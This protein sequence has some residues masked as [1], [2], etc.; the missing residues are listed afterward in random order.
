MAINGVNIGGNRL[1]QSA[2][3]LTS[4]LASLQTQLTTGKKSTTYSGMGI[5]E[6]FAIA[7]RAQLSN[8]TGFTDTMTKIDTTI[9][10]ANTALQSLVSIGRAAQTAAANTIQTV[11]SSGQTVLQQNAYGQLSL[12]FGI[13]NTQSGD[14]FVFSGSAI[15]TPSVAPIEDVMNGKGAAAG[16][17]QVIDERRQADLGLSGLGRVVVS[18]PSATSVAVAEDVAGSPFGLKLNAISSS[19]TGAT[20]TAPA[21]SP[22]AASVALGATNPNSGERI[23]F[24][25]NLPDGTMESI[26]LIATSA[27]PA[28][29]G[30]FTIGATP[31]ATAAN[32]N[33]ALTAS[34]GTLAKTSLVAASA[35]EASDN[36]F[37]KPPQRV[38]GSP[39]G[40]A[41]ALVN[42]TATDTV[43]WYTGENGTGS[44]RSSATAR[45][46][47]SVT[48]QYGAR[49]NE[50]AIR[51]QLKSIAAFAAVT[52]TATDPNANA[53]LAALGSRV[54]Q[55]LTNQAGQ[56]SI[57][58]IQAD[59]SIAQ[60]TMTD[61]KARQTQ[62]RTM[63][64]SIV[65]QAENV[66]P[67]EVAAQILALQTNL[68]ASY[69]TTAM[70]AQL[71][72]TRF[73]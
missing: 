65:D 39:P 34:L 10:V 8:I 60:V 31:A 63:L 57:T 19:L 23:T 13:L 71:T 11:G 12:M 61:A 47:Q 40:S 67:S 59:F 4:E 20:V 62:N 21:G 24:S 42:A 58:E 36:F 64:Q 22:P 53:L 25:F 17:K 49:A 3:T 72:L 5:N 35:I 14:R 46:D 15:N 38:A 45:I 30:S 2:M 9:G 68:Q 55:N 66:S 33:T 41:T 27:A 69:Q 51:E 1:G 6:G 7:A 26:A 28:A 52:T 18:Q 32:L 50:T 16:L 54:S 44:A 48:I 70:L 43:S 29:A 37:D 73:L 56:P